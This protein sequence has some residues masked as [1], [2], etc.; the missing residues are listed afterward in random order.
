MFGMAVWLFLLLLCYGI[1][2]FDTLT[3]YNKRPVV[4]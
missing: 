3:S 4:K 1:P 2:I